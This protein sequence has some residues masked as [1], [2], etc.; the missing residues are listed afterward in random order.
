M[1]D[2]SLHVCLRACSVRS[3]LLLQ[4]GSSA[5]VRPAWG[6]ISAIGAAL[7][8]GTQGMWPFISLSIPCFCSKFDYILFR[9]TGQSEASAS[10]S[11]SETSSQHFAFRFLTP[12]LRRLFIGRK[13]RSDN[14]PSIFQYSDLRACVVALDLQSARFHSL[15]YAVCII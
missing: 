7:F 12:F 14:L 11:G 5:S 6:Y 4:C 1:S 2:A 9:H 3:K 10:A 8:W 13:C 15:G